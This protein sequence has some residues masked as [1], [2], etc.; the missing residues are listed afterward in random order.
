MCIFP[1]AP[2]DEFIKNI[3]YNSLIHKK[4]EQ[5]T[6]SLSTSSALSGAG[7]N[8][9]AWKVFTVNKLVEINRQ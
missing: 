5:A 8:A 9:K 6:P 1:L 3:N 4:Q 2:L 7:D